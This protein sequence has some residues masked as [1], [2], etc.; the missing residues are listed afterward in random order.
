MLLKII[1]QYR[2]CVHMLTSD[3]QAAAAPPSGKLSKHANNS[4][5]TVSTEQLNRTFPVLIQ[6][7]VKEYR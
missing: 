3:L 4:I 2:Y 6:W 5:Y 1:A 7:D